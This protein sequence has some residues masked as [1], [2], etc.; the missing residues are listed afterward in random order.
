VIALAERHSA[1]GPSER[2]SYGASRDGRIDEELRA[3]DD[4]SEGLAG[5][6]RVVFGDQRARVADDATVAIVPIGRF[7]LRSGETILMPM[8]LPGRFTAFQYSETRC[9]VQGRTVELRMSAVGVG[10]CLIRVTTHSSVNYKDGLAA[11]GR[12]AVVQAFPW[13]GGT[14]A[15]GVVGAG[16]SG[17]VKAADRVAVTGCTLSET[18]NGR[19]ASSCVSPWS[20]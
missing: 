7:G 10:D 2:A 4:A 15:V 3:G 16:A 6:P 19:Y 11:T 13:V 14:D 1:R 12:A 5:F 18:R 20:G 8:S 17:L 9:G